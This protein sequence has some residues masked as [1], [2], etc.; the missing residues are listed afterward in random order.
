M[1]ILLTGAT[2]NLGQEL[3]RRADFEIVPIGRDDWA[4]IDA[5]LSRNIDVVIHAAS[6][7]RS[8]VALSPSRVLDSNVLSTAHL[9]EAMRRHRVPRVVFLSSCAV[10]GEAMQTDE[11]SRCCPISINGIS[12][13]LNEKIVAEYCERQGIKYEILRVFN[14]YGGS[15]HFSIFS[16]VQRSL[17]AG[18][19]FTLNNRGIAQ[20]D[21]IH[22]ADVAKVI[23]QL[24]KMKLPYTHIN[25]G[26][27]V[28]TRIAGLIDLI[29]ARFP[30]LTVAHTE[31]EEAEYSRANIVRLRELMECD[32]V[33]VEDYLNSEFMRGK[34]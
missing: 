30:N 26:T 24:L 13:Q 15:D 20:R 16:H 5:Q 19:P 33:R 8:S 29:S 25:V 3:R 1:K 7:L 18:I 32:F 28:A 6:D 22:V 11:T 10:Y 21:F 9:L 34:S 31:K 14:M 12:K 27:G 4:N 17:E 2:G 23:M